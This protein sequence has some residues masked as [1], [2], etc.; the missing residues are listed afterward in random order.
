[1]FANLLQLLTGQTPSRSEYDQAFVR[2]V[3]VRVREPRNRRLE[4]G[5]ILGWT[6]IAVKSALM[7]WAVD[8]YRIPLNAWWINGPTV[9]LALLCTYVYL[10]RR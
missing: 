3:T 7:V 10:R 6:L 4:L 2:D 8:R 5:L 9:M 1:M